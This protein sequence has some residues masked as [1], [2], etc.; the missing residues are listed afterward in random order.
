[1]GKRK[2]ESISKPGSQKRRRQE[3][4]DE[5][6]DESNEEEN[7]ESSADGN[8]S[9]QLTAGEVGIIESI[10]LKNFMCHSNL[11]P[12]QF[13]SN[14]NFV[15]G[16][17]GSGKSSVLT[18]LIVG[19]GGKATATNRGSSLKMFIRDGETSADI[20]ITLRNQGRDAFKPEVYGNSIIVNQRIN[21]EGSR[22]YKL[23]SK[24]GT[25]ISSKKEEL[26]KILDHYNIQVDNPVTI[27][28]QEM[29]KQ[30]LQT[31][32]ESDKY[33][34]FMKATQ[35]EQMKE[36]YSCVEKTQQNTRIQIEQGRE[37]LEELR[38]IYLEKKELYK[39]IAF[40]NDM[41]RRLEEL[42]HNM[43][44]AVVSEME[45]EIEPI[46]EGI[47]AEEANTE[48]IQK[49]E[50][51]QVKVNEAEKKYKAVQ[52]RLETV[53]EEAQA[54]HPQCISLKA[55]VQA[56][57]KAVN[58]IEV[59]YNRFKT[60]LKRL[61]KDDEQLCKRIEELKSSA[62]Q[63]PEP[64]KLERQRKIAHLREQLKAFRDEEIMIAQ[65]MDQFQQAI[66][67]CREEH[68]RV[69]RENADVQQALDAKQKQ[70][71]ELKDS[72]TD[73]LKRFGPHIPGFV[74]AVETAYKQGR[75]NKKPLGPIGAFI[76]PKD[77]ELTLAVEACLKGLVHAFCCDNHS[78]ERTLQLLMSKHYPHGF[79]PQIIVNKFQN[80]IYDVRPRA[81]Y[82]PEFPS[83]LTA[84]EI[85]HVMVANCLIDVRGIEKVLLI[86]SNRRAREVMQS[87]HPPA[88]CK[89]AFTGEGDHV[90]ERRYYSSNYSRPKYLSQDVEAE[91]S[92]LDKEIESKRAQLA[93][94]QQRLYSIENEIR[95]N[96]DH[97][98]GHRRHQK[99]LQ[100][101]IRT[102]NGEIVDLE[103]V[104]EHQSVDIRILQDEA[105][106]NK[107]KME[108]VKEDMQL[109]SR[110]MEELKNILLEAEKKLKEVKEK[111]H[112]VE[113]V[114]GPI[115]D[116]LNQA[117]SEMESS[118]RH[119]QH[120]A[121]KQKEHLACI[122]KLKELLATKEKELEE[123]TAQA[124]QI[125][126]ERI[127]VSRTV[128]SLDAEMNRFR[129]KIKSETSL[130][131]NREEIIQQFHDA[132]ERYE[133]ASSKV[134]NLK[135]FFRVLERIMA[136][137]VKAYQQFLRILSIR[138]KSSFEGLLHVRGCS[139][140]ILFDHKNETLSIT[141]QFGDEDKASL[142]DLRAL[143]G[144]E[145]TFSTV[146]YIL[147]LW[148]ITDSPF[149]CL[150]EFDVYMDMLNRRIAID[151]ILERANF[152]QYRQFILFTPQSIRSLPKSPHIRI[153]CLQDP[154]RGQRQLNFQNR[155][156]CD[157][158]Q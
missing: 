76:H 48:F 117:E 58:E 65:Q 19:L 118:K 53:S 60:E 104:E 125:Y 131:G 144:G 44:W 126:S 150:D 77:P 4:I 68:A 78:D 94:S 52:D 141:V 37:R 82:H 115:K 99:E 133:D 146:C 107:A 122:E 39:S 62:N 80:K 75:F 156:D 97:L 32:S 41:R 116:E 103:N 67:K 72:K 85:D 92:H 34:F 145:R 127:Q 137:R 66:Y 96:E 10:Q 14:I 121:D 25:L 47:K 38:Q 36:D 86:K 31:K 13:G 16:S 55:E 49:V 24:S 27:L 88:N 109:Q 74:E 64:E 40:V 110:N 18:A 114:A 140:K 151:M 83:V 51:W 79:R 101:K 69:R 46:K 87:S 153:L 29:S 100:I 128:K 59:V 129:E 148:N 26:V 93:A 98:Y 142:T 61:G 2:E 113:V 102:T 6:S 143:S 35:L 23:K 42:K 157:E 54:L 132:K 30:F 147:S 1:M 149:R 73:T 105:E 56:K 139:G 91:I 11:G 138:C 108:S 28:T 158:D 20:S 95:Q 7:L 111:I 106:E 135:K 3:Y 130:H 22:S 120:Y 112:E 21:Q 119:L 50:E 136:E 33:K 70:L 90:F 17:N 155:T 15:V 154:E 124:R 5:H 8:T 81:V 152:Q 12:F 45:K 9:S 43:A 123:K 63:V 134:K 57:R 84:L 71:R 89:E